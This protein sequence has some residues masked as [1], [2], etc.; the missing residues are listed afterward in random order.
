VLSRPSSTRRRQRRL[1]PTPGHAFHDM[2]P[3][4]VAVGDVND[5]HVLTRRWPAG[6]GRGPVNPDRSGVVEICLRDCH[7]MDFGV[8]HDAQHGDALQLRRLKSLRFPGGSQAHGSRRFL[9]VRPAGRRARHTQVVKGCVAGRNSSCFAQRCGGRAGLPQRTKPSGASG[10]E[11]MRRPVAAWMALAIAGAT[12][13]IGVSPA[14]VEG[15]SGRSST[16]MSIGG[17]SANRGTR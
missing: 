16:V 13:M 14:P 3:E 5:I 4:P 17:V 1:E 7:P 15:R 9:R 10:S 2:G 11:R 12:A 6:L 8:K